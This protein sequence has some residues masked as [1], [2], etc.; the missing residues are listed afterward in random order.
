MLPLGGVA[1]R[2]APRALPIDDLRVALR[3]QKNAPEIKLKQV[4]EPLD[5]LNTPRL[6]I[7][8]DRLDGQDLVVQF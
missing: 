1:H 5:L 6:E 2:G 4:A 3:I 8:H 7:F